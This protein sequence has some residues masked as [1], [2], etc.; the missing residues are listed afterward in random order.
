MSNRNIDPAHGFVGGLLVA[1]GILFLL[2][3]LDVLDFVIPDYVFSFPSILIIIGLLLLLSR[4]KKTAGYIFLAVGGVWMI[5]RIVPWF[6][7]GDIVL[8]M[9]FVTIGLVIIL[10]NRRNMVRYSSDGSPEHTTDIIDDVSIF[11][12]GKKIF[13]SNRFRGGSA[14]AI[15]GGSDIDLR[16]C[17]LSPGDNIID[18]F[19]L[20]GG[21]DFIVPENWDTRIEAVSIFGSFSNRKKTMPEKEVEAENRLVIK[22]LVLFGGGEIKYF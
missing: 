12:G 3:N 9:I 14:T 2:N 17:Q 15:F 16:Q 11:G 4:T 6:S 18:V 21:T 13:R 7:F 5:A 10:K 8:P 20:F 22:G 19:Y 1:V